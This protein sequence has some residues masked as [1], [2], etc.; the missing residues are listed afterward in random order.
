M[1]ERPFIPPVEFF[2]SQMSWGI[3]ET[4]FILTNWPDENELSCVGVGRETSDRLGKCSPVYMPVWRSNSECMGTKHRGIYLKLK[5]AIEKGELAIIV[6]HLP[7]IQ[8]VYEFL[9][10]REVILWALVNGFILAPDLQKALNI[11]QIN[12]PEVSIND[13]ENVRN[14]IILQ[15]IMRN[16]Q[17]VTKHFLIE[18]DWIGRFGT[19]KK[20]KTIRR[21]IDELLGVRKGLG[22]P[23]K[24]SFF[25][26]SFFPIAEVRQEQQP[27]VISF[28]FPLLRT[29][30]FTA[31]KVYVEMIGFDAFFEMNEE[32][33]LKQFLKDEII[34]GY[35][36]EATPV[37]MEIAA[38]F[39]CDRLKQFYSYPIIAVSSQEQR[40]Q[41]KI[42]QLYHD[43]DHVHLR[44]TSK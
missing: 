26:Y 10:T 29:A 44:V 19:S 16:N 11:H 5:K 13:H 12:R 40:R 43:K 36:K 23:N 6:Q 30:I 35:L 8:G 31:V 25:Q 21:S 17:K 2:L 34:H 4:M 39:I 3:H 37:E 15:C 42:R 24:D 41:M 32:E 33:F 9:S 7:A 14:K 38:R 27:G 20:P 28:N 22:R 1:D 18:H